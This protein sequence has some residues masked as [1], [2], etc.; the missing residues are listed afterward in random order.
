MSR[1]VAALQ[2]RGVLVVAA[3][4]VA[5]SMLYAA[6]R[7]PGGLSVAVPV[8]QPDVATTVAGT[9][10]TIHVLA[11]DTDALA[12]SSVTQPRHGSVT[13]DGVTLQY[14]P[15]VGYYGV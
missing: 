12:I 10:T 4:L 8:A 1:V 11:N 7:L 2:M 15:A 6:P 13:T 14:A 3:C 5:I 9:A